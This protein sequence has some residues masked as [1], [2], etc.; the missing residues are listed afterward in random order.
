MCLNY[1]ELELFN[2]VV[3]SLSLVKVIICLLRSI[4]SFIVLSL[5]INLLCFIDKILIMF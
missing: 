2:E 5:K 4:I 3:I 1:L